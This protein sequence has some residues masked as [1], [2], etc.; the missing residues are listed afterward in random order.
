MKRKQ[1][2]EVVLNA[3]K[4]IHR[5]ITARN[6]SQLKTWQF[7][8]GSEFLN[9]LL[10]DWL[11]G[12]LEAQQMFS[13]IEHPWENGRAERSFSKKIKK[14]RAMMLYADL[15]NGIW[16]RAV[17]HAVYLKNRCPSTRVNYLSP[18]QF[19]TG[20]VQD[21]S[22]LRVFGRPAQIFVRS[23]QRAT[24]KLPSR[25]EQGTFVGMS[26]IGTQ[27]TL[28]R[29]TLKA[30]NLTKRFQTAWIKKAEQLKAVEF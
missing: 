17:M 19:R 29:L 24:N 22:R 7:D 6:K 13:N 21:F 2:A 27:T 28:S 14:T 3:C 18:L 26:Q 5:I 9:E 16:G 12:D 10:D 30:S 20:A 1:K 4:K 23:K 11:T 15:P 25:S 8:R